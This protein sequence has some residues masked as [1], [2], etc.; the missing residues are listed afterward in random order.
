L[1]KEDDRR[2]YP[3][4]KAP[5]FYRP[6]GL[7]LLRALRRGKERAVD[8]SLGGVRIYSDDALTLG[9]RLD[10]DLFLPDDTTLSAKG[11]VVWVKELPEGSPARYDV[12]VRFD[13]MD[14]HDQSRL[15]EVLEHEAAAE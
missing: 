10:L 15:G 8:I 11:E 4:L 14:A 2:Q 3:R 12:G 5:V 7:A 1:A 13:K 9:E 6:T